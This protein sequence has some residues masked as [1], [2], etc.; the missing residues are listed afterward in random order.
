MT[1]IFQKIENLYLYITFNSSHPPGLLISLVT[2]RLGVYWAQNTRGRD[3]IFTTSFLF[4]N[5]LD[6]GYSEELL[7]DIFKK[8]AK[9]IDEKT[10]GNNKLPKI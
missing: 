10:N 4:F 1:K 8:T 5:L 2:G 9:R 7:R 3:F 6:R